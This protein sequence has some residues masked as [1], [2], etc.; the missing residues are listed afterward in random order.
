MFNRGMEHMASYALDTVQIILW[1]ATYVEIIYLG[2]RYHDLN[3]SMP[4]VSGCLNL[5]WEMNSIFQPGLV[6]GRLG[7]LI[8]DAWIFIQNAMRLKDSKRQYILAEVIFLALVRWIFVAVPLGM[9]KS[10]FSIDLIMAVDYIV[11]Q[12]R[13]SFHG[14]VLVAATKLLGDLCAWLYYS[15]ESRFVILVG[16]LVFLCNLFYL[17]IAMEVNSKQKKRRQKGGP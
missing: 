17:A 14:Q 15:H 13:I 12:K 6:L 7:W 8:L 16:F 1:T 5:A 10:V 3:P 4:Y 11:E 2:C 9:L